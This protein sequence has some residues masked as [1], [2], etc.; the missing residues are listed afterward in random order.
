M[1]DG[2]QLHRLPTGSRV[3][4]TLVELALEHNWRSAVCTGIGGVTDVELAY[5]D[6]A[7]KTYQPIHVPGIIELVSLNGNLT[8]R[9]GEPF[10][11]LHAIVSD[12][13][14]KCWAGHVNHFVV[15]LTVE[16]AVWPSDQTYLREFDETL[17]LRL[18]KL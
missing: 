2:W 18:L 10:W 14:G 7:T 8:G 3:P 5:F 9:D 17:G 15:A 12:A 1:T 13:S 16:L 4:D 11:H 6:L